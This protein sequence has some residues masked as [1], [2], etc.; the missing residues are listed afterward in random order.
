MERR[1]MKPLLVV[2]VGVL[3]VQVLLFSGYFAVSAVVDRRNV[4]R[5]W[6]VSAGTS[7]VALFLFMFVRTA[8]HQC[9]TFP[10]VAVCERRNDA[11]DTQ[12]ES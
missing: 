7:L 9:L 4:A 12:I 6:L 10:S 3:V 1:S 8:C 11:V 2:V 5:V